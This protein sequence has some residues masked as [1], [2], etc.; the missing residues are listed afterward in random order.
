MCVCA[1]ASIS[2]QALM[3][4]RLQV[5]VRCSVQNCRKL[6][7]P[8]FPGKAAVC[9]WIELSPANPARGATR[10]KDKLNPAIDVLVSTF[11][12]TPISWSSACIETWFYDELCGFSGFSTASCSPSTKTCHGQCKVLVPPQ[13]TRSMLQYLQQATTKNELLIQVLSHLAMATC[14]SLAYMQQNALARTHLRTCRNMVETWCL[15]H[16]HGPNEAWKD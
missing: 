5:R 16:K 3:T 7:S 1:D 8:S 14:R 11:G 13:Y 2:Q 6:G 4:H 15:V 9:K 10:Q 12:G